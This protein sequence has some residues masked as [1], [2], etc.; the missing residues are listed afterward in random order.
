MLAVT[1]AFTDKWRRL[2]YVKVYLWINIAKY[3]QKQTVNFCL[4]AQHICAICKAVYIRH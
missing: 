4:N 3:Q 2:Q 1:T